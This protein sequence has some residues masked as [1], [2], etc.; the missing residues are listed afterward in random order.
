MS[1]VPKD[2]TPHSLDRWLCLHDGQRTIQRL[3]ASV[4]KSGRIAFSAKIR[5]PLSLGHRRAVMTPV[6]FA[7]ICG[8]VL[9]LRADTP[10]YIVADCLSDEGQEGT[11]MVRLLQ[12]LT[13][14]PHS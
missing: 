4:L 14:Q 9:P 5:T 7:R 8:W 13:D 1:F 2:I 11:A 6:R 12:L 3:Y 10:L